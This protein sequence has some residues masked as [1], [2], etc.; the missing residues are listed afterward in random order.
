LVEMRGLRYRGE[1][2]WELIFSTGEVG[3]GKKG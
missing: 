3:K 1:T 2:A